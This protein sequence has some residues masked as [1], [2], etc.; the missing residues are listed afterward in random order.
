MN[1]VCEQMKSINI[2]GNI[3]PISWYKHIKTKNG[4]IDHVAITLLAD[5]IYWYRPIEIRDQTSGNIIEY[6]QKFRADKLQKSY[7]EYAALFGYSKRQVK[8][9]IDNLVDLSL[10]NREFRNIRTK[11]G[12]P[13]NNVMFL[14]PI[15]DNIVDLTY[16]V[17]Y[18][19]N[20]GRATYNRMYVTPTPERRT[21]TKTTTKTT[22]EITTKEKRSLVSNQK[23]FDTIENFQEKDIPDTK[24]Q[25]AGD[26]NKDWS[27]TQEYKIA[28]WFKSTLPERMQKDVKNPTL[29]KWSKTLNDC[30]RIDGFSLERVRKILEWARADDFWS[31]QI[32]SI[33][34]L[35]KMSKSLGFKYL[36]VLDEKMGKG[37]SGKSI[38]D[39]EL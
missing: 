25:N 1:K 28:E 33:E 36:L 19:T 6:K 18:G 12:L 13:I 24:R 14:E 34:K 16:R 10:L 32:F 20:D 3:I 26:K 27:G 9:A 15:I 4:S 2:E 30:V 31:K 11:S 5:I 8:R 22:T 7:G 17:E 35:R 39:F 38:L 21:N 29:N 37:G 23:P